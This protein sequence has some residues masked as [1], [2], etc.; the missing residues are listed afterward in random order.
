MSSKRTL[1]ILFLYIT[2]I[3][4]L[5]FFKTTL[6]IY[7]LY[8]LYIFL[9]SYITIYKKNTHRRFILGVYYSYA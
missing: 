6:Y 9:H 8:I 2:Y 7:Y 3:Y 5:V 1:Y 4:Y